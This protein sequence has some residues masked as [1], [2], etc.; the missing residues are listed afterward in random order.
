MADTP[1]SVPAGRLELTDDSLKLLLHMDGVDASTTF[2]DETGKTITASGNAQIDTAQSKFGGASC[3]LDGTGDF[4]SVPD[5]TDFEPGSSDFTFECWIRPTVNN[6]L[7][8]IG[9]KRLNTGANGYWNI[10][11]NASGKLQLVCV[12][13]DG[14]TTIINI[15][16]STTVTTA[17]WHHVAISKI[18]T[19]WKIFLDGVQENSAV[20]TAIVGTAGAAALNI[21]RDASNTTRDFNG[22]IDEAAVFF[23]RALYT[24]AF[25][26]RTD[27]IAFTRP[28]ITVALPPVDISTPAGAETIAGQA[29][30]ISKY[31]SVGLGNTTITGHAPEASI[32]GVFFPTNGEISVVGMGVTPDIQYSISPPDGT[33]LFSG[34]SPAVNV[35][36]SFVPDVGALTLGGQEVLAA[37]PQFIVGVAGAHALTGQAVLPVVGVVALPDAGGITITGQAGTAPIAWS[38]PA[39]SL[40][41]IGNAPALYIGQYLNVDAGAHSFTG[42]A[43]GHKTGYA[44]SAGATTLTGQAPVVSKGVKMTVAGAGSASFAGSAP[45]IPVIASPSY[46]VVTI[47]ALF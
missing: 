39:G 4:L 25:I 45:S 20:E 34:Q 23:G 44:V 1:I 6:V 11:V 41:A 22:H 13:E 28:A 12:A 31:V 14:T 19:T 18:G 36:Y 32:F 9:G 29:V 2:T 16:G 3:L 46:N 26:P 27:P 47:E 15:S 10:Y 40:S 7:K 30:E 24:S 21:G 35:N 8:C 17:T 33:S 38:F 5:S 43:F 42:Q 37:T